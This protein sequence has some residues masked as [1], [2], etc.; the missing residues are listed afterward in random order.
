MKLTTYSVGGPVEGLCKQH[1]VWGSNG[2]Q[3]CPLIF[4]QRPK[5]I[6]DDSAWQKIVDGVKLELPID[7]EIT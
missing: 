4:L 5:W 7:F 2:V 1:A 3:S 6:K